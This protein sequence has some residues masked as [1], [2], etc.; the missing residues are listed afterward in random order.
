VNKKTFLIREEV[1]EAG[2]PPGHWAGCSWSIFVIFF[3]DFLFQKL[4][5]IQSFFKYKIYS[6]Y[7][8][9]CI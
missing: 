5:E 4:F 2:L 9:V 6:P 1:S 7:S 3:L 8:Y